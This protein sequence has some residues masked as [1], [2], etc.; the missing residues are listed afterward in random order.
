[1]TA[2]DRYRRCRAFARATSAYL[3]AFERAGWAPPLD[4]EA[5]RRHEAHAW[6]RLPDTARA[7]IAPPPPSTP[8]S[9]QVAVDKAAPLAYCPGPWQTIDRGVS[10]GT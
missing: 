2:R 6:E 9:P 4:S 10:R 3:L 5:H 8:H 7:T 1:M